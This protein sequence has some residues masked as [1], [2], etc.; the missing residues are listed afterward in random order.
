[1]KSMKFMKFFIGVA[2]LAIGASVFGQSVI[3]DENFQSFKEQ[4]SLHAKSPSFWD[5]QKYLKLIPVSHL[6]VA[7]I[8]NK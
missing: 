1:M 3:I 2:L 7:S 4:L 8:P 5:F 6:F